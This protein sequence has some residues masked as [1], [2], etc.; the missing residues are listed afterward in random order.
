MN[1][2]RLAHLVFQSHQL[3]RHLRQIDRLLFFKGIHVARDVEVVVVFLDLAQLG[4][5]AE[6]LDAFALPV[7]A[8]DALDVFGAELAGLLVFSKWALASMKR[9]SSGFSRCFFSTRMQVG[10][11]VP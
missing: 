1:F 8:D 10:M 3:L 7:G 2:L 11:P 9:M 4:D 5:V 6:F